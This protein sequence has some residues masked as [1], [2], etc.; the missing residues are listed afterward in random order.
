MIC[1]NVPSYQKIQLSGHK[2]VDSIEDYH[3]IASIKHQE[4]MSRIILVSYYTGL[5]L[6][7][8]NTGSFCR[9]ASTLDTRIN[10]VNAV[11]QQQQQIQSSVSATTTILPLQTQPMIW[12]SCNN[13]RRN[14]HHELI[15]GKPV[16]QFITTI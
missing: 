14:F 12:R 5:V 11:K 2:R 6:Y 15:N 3:K 4:E 13:N 8:E 9:T 16:N 1:V 7:C 10:K